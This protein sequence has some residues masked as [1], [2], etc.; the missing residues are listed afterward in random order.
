MP[1]PPVTTRVPVVVEVDPVPSVNVTAPLAAN[2]PVPTEPAF[3]APPTPRPPV[4]MAA[5]VEVEEE[6]VALVTV[7]GAAV[8][9]FPV[10]A[11]PSVRFVV[12]AVVVEMVSAVNVFPP[13]TTTAPDP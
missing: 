6:A 12:D 7:R 3:T 2:A 4:M 11:T 1:T 10:P 13:V 8:V 5:P 9:T